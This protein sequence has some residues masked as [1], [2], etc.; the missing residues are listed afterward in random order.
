MGLLYLKGLSHMNV[1]S[2]FYPILNSVFKNLLFLLARQF[3]ELLKCEDGVF[4]LEDGVS[5]SVET[6]ERMFFEGYSICAFVAGS[7]IRSVYT[8]FAIFF[9]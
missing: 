4:F 7:L 8:V 3:S 5:R 2:D 6:V 1:I 9:F